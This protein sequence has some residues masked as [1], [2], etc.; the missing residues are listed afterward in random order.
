MVRAVKA[1]GRFPTICVSDMYL[2]KQADTDGC[3]QERIV[4]RFRMRDKWVAVR[5]HP[6]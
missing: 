6:S 1:T 5:D 4:E 3:A 2:G